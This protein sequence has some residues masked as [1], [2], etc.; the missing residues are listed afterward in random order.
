MKTCIAYIFA[1]LWLGM[2][3][4]EAGF[5]GFQHIV[6]VVQENRTPD[7]LFF[8]LCGKPRRCSVNPNSKQY[9][10]QTA[11]WLD[12]HA[13]DGT[14]EP[15]AVPLA[16]NYSATHDHSAFVN[17]CD[18]DA[19]SGQCLMDAAGDVRCNKGNCPANASFAYVEN[20]DGILDPYLAL[21]RQYGWANFMFQTNQGPSFPAHQ[22]I[23]GATSAPSQ[24]DDHAGYFVSEN[25]I[26]KGKD[27]CTAKSTETVPVIDPYGNEDPKNRVFPCFERTTL[28]D[29]LDADQSS[30][31]YYAPTAGSMWNAPNAIAHICVPENGDCTG[32]S[33]AQNVD[34]VPADVL[35]DIAN[36]QLRNVAWVIPTGQNSDHPLGNTG[37]GPSWVASIVNAVGTSRCKNADQSSYWDS[38]AILVTWDDWGGWYDHEAPEFLP[39]PE[40]GY[41]Y[42]FR[43]PFLFISAHTPKGYID[44][45]RNDFGSIVRFVESNFGIGEGALTFADA[46]ATGDL[47][48]FVDKEQAPRRFRKIRAPLSERYFIEDNSPPTPP[49]DE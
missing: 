39:Y 36:C 6:I 49:D 42:G 12:K 44:N 33:W 38:T 7:N 24:A 23:F 19:H 32:T 4:A 13:A 26:D 15:F 29:L 22:F 31:K 16:N 8:A 46:R 11:H 47:W 41:Q 28:A 3:F 25:K 45:R 21:A 14:R 18:L 2:G 5:A 9:D 27:G 34:L 10:I 17:Q 35:T 48:E 43:V 1:L 37:G 30:W 20:A 40:G